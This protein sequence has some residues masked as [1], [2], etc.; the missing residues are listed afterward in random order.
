LITGLTN[1]GALDAKT[2]S[3]KTLKG[4]LTALKESTLE[5]RKLRGQGK[6]PLIADGGLLGSLKSSKSKLSFFRYGLYHDDPDG[7]ITKNRFFAGDKLFNFYK[8]GK[9]VQVPGRPWV[10]RE[11]TPENIKKFFQGFRKALKK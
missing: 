7:F 9:G 3:S 4:G 1:R 8:K 5:T 6:K 10:F 2:Q 11:Y